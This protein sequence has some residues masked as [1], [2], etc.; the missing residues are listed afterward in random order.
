[1]PLLARASVV[2]SSS[3][4]PSLSVAPVA[5]LGASTDVSFSNGSEL[6][7]FVGV[8]GVEV[9]VYAVPAALGRLRLVPAMLRVWL[10]CEHG[11][12]FA[13]HVLGLG[14]L[15]FWVSSWKLEEGEAYLL[16]SWAPGR[17]VEQLQILV[18]GELL[19]HLGITDAI[20]KR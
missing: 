8:V 4:S 2:P 1:M 6:L 19:F 9:V 5:A 12:S 11:C 14:L 18:D 17:Q 16:S 10:C 7:A 3:T 15:L 13:L 20:R